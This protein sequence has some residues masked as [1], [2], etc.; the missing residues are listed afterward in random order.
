MN[1]RISFKI[2]IST[3][4]LVCSVSSHAQQ[5][6]NGDVVAVADGDTLTILDADLTQYR[7]R[8]AGIDAP[9]K[10]QPFGQVAKQKLSA[11]C[12]D[13]PAHI[14]V[15]SIDRY[16]RVVGDVTCDQVHANAEMVRTGLAWVYRQYAKNFEYLLP[17]E[18]AA[19]ES[20][21][22]LWMDPR[23]TPPW[24]WRRNNLTVFH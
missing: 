4:A 10:S 7:I 2:V 5:T 1:L 20:R 17:L 19:R 15:V 23:P 13:K 9:E 3:L 18:K 8:L 12:Y 16:N 24:Q 6:L 21:V 14:V 11:L 22:G